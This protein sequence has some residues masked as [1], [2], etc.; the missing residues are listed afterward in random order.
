MLFSGLQG[1]GKTT[2]ARRL[3]SSIGAP[4]FAKDRFQSL[5]R[6]EKLPSRSTAHGY[7][8]ILDM[9]DEQLGLGLSVILDAVFPMQGFRVLAS[10]IAERHSARFKP[11]YC[12]CSDEKIWKIRIKERRNTYIPHWS[13]VDWYEVER[14]RGIFDSWQPEST[15]FIDTVL[16]FDTNLDRI[17][18]WIDAV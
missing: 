8:L 3:A 6:R 10:D 16:D 14:F 7:Q 5:L 12:Y 18:A 11:I 13:P 2:L 1:C 17:L 15:L 4:L 9:A